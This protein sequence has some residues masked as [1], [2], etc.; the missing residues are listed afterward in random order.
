MQSGALPVRLPVRRL[1]SVVPERSG[2]NSLCCASHAAQT[3]RA[4]TYAGFV[5]HRVNRGNQTHRALQASAHL[6]YWLETQVQG[7]QFG[8]AALAD[9]WNFGE[10][11]VARSHSYTELN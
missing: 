4:K 1:L 6:A 8:N 5:P 2:T 10:R 7:F 3:A 11:A 9:G